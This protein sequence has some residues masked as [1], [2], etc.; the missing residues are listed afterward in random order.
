MS[1][2]HLIIFFFI[3]F[4][5]FKAMIAE[6][7]CSSQ[8]EL[9]KMIKC[10]E[11]STSDVY[12]T[13]VDN[14]CKEWYKECSDYQQESSK[15][16]DN[17]CNKIEP[18]YSYK[19]C[20]VKNSNDKKTCIEEFKPCSERS[21]DTCLPGHLADPNKRCVLKDGKCE[22]HS[23]SCSG[24]DSTKCVA[25]IPPNFSKKC[26]L[27]DTGCIEEEKK[28]SDFVPYKDDNNHQCYTLKA[29]SEDKVC[30]ENED[31]NCAETYKSC[32]VVKT[33]TECEKNKPLKNNYAIDNAFKCAWD[34]KESKC[35]E[36]QRLCS[37]YKKGQN[38][39]NLCLSFTTEYPKYKHCAYDSSD[40][41]VEIYTSCDAYNHVVTEANKRNAE[42]CEAIEPF[43]RGSKKC[44]L[45]D[46]KECEEVSKECIDL[47]EEDE[48]NSFYLED[49]S[50][51]CIFLKGECKEELKNCD[52]FS[53]DSA[54][55]SEQNKEK[56]ES[57]SPKE[58]N[59]QTGNK[60]KCIYSDSDHK[61]TKKEIEKCEDYKG[62]SNSF[63]TNIR[64]DNS[65]NFDISCTFKDNQC[66]TQ[67]NDCN[68]YNNIIRD[69]NKRKKE[70]CEALII[71]SIYEKCIFDDEIKRCESVSLHCSEYRGTNPNECEQF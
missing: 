15:F 69:E 12:C 16:D 13:F 19:K 23:N 7:E 51:K 25:N 31:N 42:D 21:I 37:E 60:Y 53:Y 62:Y 33:Q 44:I 20:V 39:A 50:K 45:N 34:S 70:E 35:Q 49:T 26:S 66:I 14:Q 28:C 36:K 8:F 59:Y 9:V 6:D 61:C 71:N 3:I 18:P 47:K 52:A 43:E 46:K 32:D 4:L 65:M 63:C 68:S 67:Y 55:T 2:K 56:C 17:I 41:C 38:N 48:C 5:S 40:E 64:F 11:L 1:Q 10:N 22:E 57:I 27:K 54:L 30:Y 29:S 24:L 58:D